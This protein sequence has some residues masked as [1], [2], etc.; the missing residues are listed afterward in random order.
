MKKTA[1]IL[2]K[3]NNID[4]SFTADSKE[5]KRLLEV[6]RVE[7]AVSRKQEK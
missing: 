7:S 3:L 1:Q 2:K 4:N 5:I 6:I